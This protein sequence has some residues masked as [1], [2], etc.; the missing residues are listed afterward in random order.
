MINNFLKSSYLAFAIVGSFGA[1]QAQEV[2]I[3]IPGTTVVNPEVEETNNLLARC[4]ATGLEEYCSGVSLNQNGET[5]ESNSAPDIVLETFIIDLNDE[6][7][8]QRPK[9]SVSTDTGTE[10]Q[11]DQPVATQSMTSIGIE[12]Q[13][14]F[15]SNKIRTDQVEKMSMLAIALA[16]KINAGARFAIIGHTDGKGSDAYNCGLSKKRATAVTT[17]LLINGAQNYLL[18]VGAGE[19]LLKNAGNP[20]SEKNRRVSFLKLGENEAATL[21]AFKS[22][23][24]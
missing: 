20:N 9:V 18:S 23:C 17:T 7:D 5:L 2:E 10:D 15:N 3:F 19:A 12:I 14:D 1:V 13:F 22:L 24:Q 4:L 16:D 21:N 11:K 8:T 6:Q